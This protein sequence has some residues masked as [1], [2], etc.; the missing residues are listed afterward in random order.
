MVMEQHALAVY[1]RV[2]Q[3]TSGFRCAAG[4]PLPASARKCKAVGRASSRFIGSELASG[5]ACS[6]LPLWP[7]TA[8]WPYS[9]SGNERLAALR[10]SMSKHCAR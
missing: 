4:K 5:T 7:A 6:E 9:A 1:D 8:L 2:T 10:R 3:P